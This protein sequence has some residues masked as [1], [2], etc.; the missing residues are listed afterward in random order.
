MLYIHK[1]PYLMDKEYVRSIEVTLP[2][3]FHAFPADSCP[4]GEINKKGPNNG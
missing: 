4:K 3:C 1:V 2:H